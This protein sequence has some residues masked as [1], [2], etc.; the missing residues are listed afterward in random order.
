MIRMIAIASLMLLAAPVLAQE[1]LPAPAGIE[2]QPLAAPPDVPQSTGPVSLAP[3]PADSMPAPAVNQTPVSP[4]EGPEERALDQS[5]GLPTTYV[6][7]DSAPAVKPSPQEDAAIEAR[8]NAAAH[9]QAV[10]PA[11]AA[12]PPTQTV[13]APPTHPSTVAPASTHWEGPEERALDQ[14]VPGTDQVAPDTS[15]PDDAEV[16]RLN[17]G[18]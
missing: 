11:P 8:I 7:A 13:Y 1:S 16:K 18:N 6:P 15:E 17:G 5:L 3:P 10:P 2:A 9:G 4:H 14:A 12:T